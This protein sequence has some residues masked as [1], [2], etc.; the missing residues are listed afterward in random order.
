[1]KK[2][3]KKKKQSNYANSFIRDMEEKQKD[4]VRTKRLY[5]FLNVFSFSLLGF[6]IYSWFN[7]FKN[8]GGSFGAWIIIIGLFL[9]AFAVI[10]NARGGMGGH[11]GD[12]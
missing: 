3:K 5:T 11:E 2:V 10:S 4:F 6:G 9:F 1:M 12:G 7:G 8:W